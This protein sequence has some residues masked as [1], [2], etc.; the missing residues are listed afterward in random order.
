MCLYAVHT[1]VVWSVYVCMIFICVYI[2]LVCV[3]FIFVCLHMMCICVHMSFICFK[4]VSYACMIFV[5]CLY[6]LRMYVY[7]TFSYVWICFRMYIY[8]CSNV[9]LWCSNLC[10]WLLY[11][12]NLFFCVFYN[13]P[14]VALCRSS[15]CLLIFVCFTWF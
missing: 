9:V 7:L 4:W 12:F 3:Y 5:M 1:F 13:K 10:I 6:E 11:A 15:V 14:C 2:V 8:I